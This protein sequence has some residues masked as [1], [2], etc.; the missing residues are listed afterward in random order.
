MTNKGK[1]KGGAA[2]HPGGS[3][4]FF[5]NVVGN[6][7][8]FA[9]PLPSPR[10]TAHQTL[11]RAAQ[12]QETGR[13]DEAEELLKQALTFLPEHAA[14]WHLRG[15]VAL[16][17]KKLDL[18]TN[19]V[20]RAIQLNPNIALFHVNMTEICRQLKRLDD[21]IRYGLKG[22]S[23]DPSFAPAH[24][25]L[26]AAYFDN[27]EYDRAEACQRAALKLN[28]KFAPALNNLGNILRI[29]KEDEAALALFRAAAASQRG[30]TEAWSNIVVTLLGLRRYAEALEAA[31]ALVTLRPNHAAAH[32]YKGQALVELG[33]PSEARASFD[34]AIKLQPGFAEAHLE[35]GALLLEAGALEEAEKAFQHVIAL[36]DR[37]PQ[38]AHMLAM[39]KKEIKPG[40]PLIALLALEAAKPPQSEESQIALQFALGEVYDRT[41]EP[42]RAFPHFAEGCRLKRQRLK[43][44]AAATDR[45]FDSIAS[46]FSP[47][48]IRQHEGSGDPSDVPVFV[49][50]MPRS[51]TTLVEQIIASH[52]DVHGAGELQDL[53]AVAHG[54]ITGYDGAF[55]E[56][57]RALK[58]GILKEMGQKYISGLAKR[59]PESRRITDKMPSNFMYIGLIRLMLPRAK[60]VHVSRNPMDTCLSC[61]TRVFTGDHLDFTYD[62][63]ELGRYYRG[64][65]R[66]MAHWRRILPAGSFYD[67]QYEDLVGDIDSEARRLVEY[68]GIGWDDNCLAFYNTKRNVRTASVTQ[69]RQ[70]IYNSSVQRWRKYERFLGPLIEALGDTLPPNP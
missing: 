22:V 31:D 59:S 42:D 7:T 30:Y 43:Y 23:L 50:G 9:A 38:A 8:P 14:G 13:L 12:L 25:N 32:C 37:I 65:A 2:G 44:D 36:G 26:G 17:Q 53:G 57:M 66:L 29:K 20:G 69:V 68:C 67:I 5:Q 46:V 10:N 11:A 6:A 16:G 48:F 62:L 39:A 55:P 54:P 27:K 40:D 52:P 45:F 19:Y 15:M 4:I 1:N 63:A 60:I 3:N 49:L 61:F 64:Y 58:S 34:A 70:P 21:A 51:G 18:A 41:G 56:A 47:E 24:R 35:R 28:P 33:R